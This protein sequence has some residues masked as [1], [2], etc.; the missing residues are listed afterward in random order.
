MRTDVNY[1]YEVEL[2]MRMGLNLEDSILET[3]EKFE[4]DRF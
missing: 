4:Y 2:N 3:L 1:R